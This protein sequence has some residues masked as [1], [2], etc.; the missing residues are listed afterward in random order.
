M[1]TGAYTTLAYGKG[2]SRP[3]FQNTESKVQR[4]RHKN[5]RQPARGYTKRGE[6]ILEK[7]CLNKKA[8]I[9]T[10][11]VAIRKGKGTGIFKRAVPIADPDTN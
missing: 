3:K 9:S 5:S 6:N 8:M 4:H 2:A 11:M 10:I 1:R 7:L